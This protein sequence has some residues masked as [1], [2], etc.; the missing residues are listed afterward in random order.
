MGATRR[1]KYAGTLGHIGVFSFNQGK[2]LTS[3]E[4]G[5]I[6]TYGDRLAERCRLLMNHGEAVINDRFNSDCF[7]SIAPDYNHINLNDA[8]YGFNLRMTEI[9]AAMV[10]VQL[11]KFDDLLSKRLNN[12]SDL[13]YFLNELPGLKIHNMV[14]P[15]G[16]RHSYYALPLLFDQE[17]WGV[18]RDIVVNAVKA[19]LM[20]CAG[21]ADEG[22]TISNGYIKPIWRMPV[23]SDLHVKH[24]DLEVS[25]TPICDKL[26][27]DDL[28]LL[29]R[30]FGPNAEPGD[31]GQVADAFKKVWDNKEELK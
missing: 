17:V 30:F 6:C 22:V 31:M 9:Q 27:K 19:E 26:W 4:G 28:I 23:F 16:Y 3:G 7:S 11:R 18:H 8:I 21:R 2:H 12:V 15:D 24:L 13:L 29:H 10:R 25:L 14:R 20:P 5:M 1:G